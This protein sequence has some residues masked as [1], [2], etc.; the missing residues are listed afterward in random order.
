MSLRPSH[1]I[2]H[3]KFRGRVR[4]WRV[5]VKGF[6]DAALEIGESV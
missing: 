1:E 5:H 3:V 2:S 6:F 4:K